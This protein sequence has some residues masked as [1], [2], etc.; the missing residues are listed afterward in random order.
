MTLAREH[1]EEYLGELDALGKRPETLR[2]Y[3]YEL[4]RWLEHCEAAAIDPLTVGRGALRDYVS[5]MQ[6]RGLSANTVYLV[7]SATRR[8]YQWLGKRGH[9]DGHLL[10]GY[11]LPR[12]GRGSRRKRLPQ[13]LS[14]AEIVRLLDT[15]DRWQFGLRDRAILETLYGTGCRVSE[16]IAFD[17]TD[18][19]LEARTLAV[20]EG[21]GGKARTVLFGEPCAAALGE[22][23]VRAR[24]NLITFNPDPELA[25]FVGRSGR[26]LTQSAIQTLVKA[27]G[28]EAGLHV[29]PHLLRHSFA[30]HLLDGG[31][32]VRLVQE[33]LGHTDVETTAIYM[34]VSK[35]RLAETA[36]A[37]WAQLERKRPP[38]ERKRV[39]VGGV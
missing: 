3:R 22:Y 11:T 29:Y 34:H 5:A 36:E 14:V 1:L 6:A 18:L 9:T 2:G 12:K 33:L 38:V 37:A 4:T 32:D 28:R 15:P 8:W 39:G 19:D 16:L 10:R 25:L 17:L 26:R 21:K 30:T 20:R 31:A 24:R 23:L 7:A 27:H 35:A 13:V